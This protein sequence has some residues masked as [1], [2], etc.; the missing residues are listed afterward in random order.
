MGRGREG[1]E[2][3]GKGE[4]GRCDLIRFDLVFDIRLKF[5]YHQPEDGGGVCKCRRK[6]CKCN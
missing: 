4:N 5:W 6:V 1:R 2:G 3:K